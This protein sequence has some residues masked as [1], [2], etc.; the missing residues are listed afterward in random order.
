M[1]GEMCERLER[2]CTLPFVPITL[3]ITRSTVVHYLVLVYAP[4]TIA[5]ILVNP[6]SLRHVVTIQLTD[7]SSSKRAPTPSTIPHLQQLT[8]FYIRNGW[9]Q[10]TTTAGGICDSTGRLEAC[11][12]CLGVIT[13]GGKGRICKY[14]SPVL[15][16]L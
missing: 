6:S 9:A 11:G 1:D 3:L 8:G 10:P 16:S 2:N 4:S 13:E 15:L 14:I 7:A 12:K 5:S